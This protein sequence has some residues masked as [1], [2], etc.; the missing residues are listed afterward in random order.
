MRSSADSRSEQ[1]LVDRPGEVEE[2]M[3]GPTRSHE[4]ARVA[5]VAGRRGHDVGT[6]LVALPPDGR[7]DP[8]HQPLRVGP[9]RGH[10]RDGGLDHPAERPPPPGMGAGE[11]SR[12]GVE[13]DD[14][15]AVGHQHCQDEAGHRRHQGVGVGDRRP[16]RP[17]PAARARPL[18]RRACRGPGWPTT[19]SSTPA[20][21]AGRP[22]GGSRARPRSSSPTWRARLSESYGPARDPAVA[23]WSPPRRGRSRR[24]RPRS[25]P[26]I[27]PRSARRVEISALVWTRESEG[28]IRRA[29]LL[30][31]AR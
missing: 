29:R 25:G 24:R 12:L 22:V 6:D 10:R 7:P 27:P 8:G 30:T 2:P 20:P 5:E 28:G 26:S 11:H 16:A 15:R 4:P 3:F 23:A 18:P 17:G 31:V 13:Q 19:R 1:D 21:S 9:E 14:R